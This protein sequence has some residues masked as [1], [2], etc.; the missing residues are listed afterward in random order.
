MKKSYE[1]IVG[2]VKCVLY[3]CMNNLSFKVLYSNFYLYFF[4]KF[5]V[6]W[7]NHIAECNMRYFVCIIIELCKSSTSITISP[8]ISIYFDHSLIISKMSTVCNSFPVTACVCV[9]A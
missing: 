4:H 7:L 5:P 6:G 8:M 2:D 9:G 1:P 3:L